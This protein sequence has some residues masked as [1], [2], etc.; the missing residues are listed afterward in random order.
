MDLISIIVPVYK[1]E[2]FLDR[3]VESI[4]NQ[5]YRNLEI[6]LVD[7]GSPD[8]CPIMCDGWMKK[9]KRIKVIHKQNGGLSD[10]RNAGLAIAS[11]EF[12][13]F[14][15]SD[16]WIAPE[17]YE[18]L[19]EALR[20]D[21]SAIAACGVEMVWKDETPRRMLTP[22]INCV[23]DTYEAQ[24][25]LI[26]ESNLKQ[27]VWYKLYRRKTI[28]GILFEKGKYHEDVFWSYQAIGNAN[29]VSIIDYIGYYY[30]QRA[31]SIMGAAYSL[32]RLDVIEAYCN[33]YEYFKKQFQK[34]EQKALCAIW[35]NCI[36][37]GQMALRFLKKNEQKTAFECLDKAKDKYPLRYSD[38]SSL[39]PTHRIWIVMAKRSL[40]AACRMKNWLRVGL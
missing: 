2:D 15:D 19:L 16:D 10:A 38:Y 30:W 37:H 14:V 24:L 23:M 27:P 29:K 28:E 26:E 8:R 3:C 17:M 6:I 39:S 25:A 32:K 20:S 13:G 18:R 4:I 40:K 33:R 22:Q 11:G 9:D 34:L 36:Y 31:G 12:I 5:T 35:E 21:G 1:V 7:D